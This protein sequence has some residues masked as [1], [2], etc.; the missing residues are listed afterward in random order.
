VVSIMKKEESA[1]VILVTTI[2]EVLLCL[3]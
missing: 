3:K 1:F 2:I